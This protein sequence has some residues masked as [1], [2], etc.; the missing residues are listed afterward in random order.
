MPHDGE[1]ELCQKL[2]ILDNVQDIQL[3]NIYR[4][5][6]AITQRIYFLD[7]LS[8]SNQLVYI[9]TGN[10]EIEFGYFQCLSEFK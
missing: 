6:K 2:L 1:S 5:M 10:F 4:T 9:V 8:K 7:I 3:A